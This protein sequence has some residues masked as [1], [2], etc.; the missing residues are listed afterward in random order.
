MLPE[1]G[2]K[3]SGLHRLA[4]PA[5][6]YAGLSC[7]FQNGAKTANAE[8]RMPAAQ[9]LP[10]TFARRAQTFPTRTPNR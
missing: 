6:P 8:C 10:A 7:A 4:Q 5:G 9:S 3:S 1:F 2:E